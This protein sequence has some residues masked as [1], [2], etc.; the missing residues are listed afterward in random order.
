MVEGVRA[1]GG[2]L[3]CQQMTKERKR[4]STPTPPE[5]E[6]TQR[7]CGA[8]IHGNPCRNAFSRAVA[9]AC[10]LVG[11]PQR[12]PIS[13]LDWHIKNARHLVQYI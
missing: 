10:G 5:K 7:P 3:M 1:G 8:M 9:C 4:N 2:D 6:L 11:R 12:S 13:A